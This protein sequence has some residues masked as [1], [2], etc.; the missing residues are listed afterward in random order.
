MTS[1]NLP[2]ELVK[3]A[4]RYAKVNHRSVPKQIEY[5]SKIGRTM[6]ENPDLPYEFVCGILIAEEEIANGDVMPYD[7]G[8]KEK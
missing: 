6:E 4:K 5:W 8:F 7:F 2:D 1:V 3:L